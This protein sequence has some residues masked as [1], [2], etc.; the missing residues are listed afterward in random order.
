MRENKNNII[1]KALSWLS[2]PPKGQHSF[3]I[4]LIIF[5]II[6]T[7]IIVIDSN[8]GL[9]EIVVGKP[10][11]KNL[12]CPQLVEFIDEKETEALRNKARDDEPNAY[13]INNKA[14]EKM[15]EDL[16]KN[17]KRISEFYDIVKDKAN[18]KD[19]KL[20]I[21]EKFSD[22][23][24]LDSK[25]LLQLSYLTAPQF[26]DLSNRALNKLEELKNR[27]ITDQNIFSIKKDVRAEVESSNWDESLNFRHLL[28]TVIE[29]SI[30]IN[31][32]LNQEETLRK[33]N[34]A[35]QKIVPVSKVFQKGQKIIAEG[36]LVT[37][38]VYS[39]YKNVQSGI[40]KNVF[41]SIIGSMLFLIVFIGVAIVYIR[42]QDVN[43]FL[44]VF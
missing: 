30:R 3:L 28:S 43:I 15:V 42:T 36:D 40:N 39:I 7:A 26:D 6:I 13:N 10:A 38:E 9:D 4:R 5:W 34:E 41:L 18:I 22:K 33:K 2:V 20:I 8:Q 1:A 16:K 29:N 44:V 25:E 21:K 12:I 35:A 31:S 23:F 32:V 14:N 27:Q 24:I 19:P 17:I 37:D 11:P